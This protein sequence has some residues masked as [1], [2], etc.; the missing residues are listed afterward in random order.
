[1][2]SKPRAL[3]ITANYWDIPYRVGSHELASL[4]VRNGWLV[5]FVSDPISPL[6]LFNIKDQLIQER[7]KLYLS[8]GRKYLDDKLWAYIPFTLLPPQNF[9]IL[10][11]KFVFKNWHRLTFPNIYKKIKSQNF[12]NVDLLYFDNA[13]QAV[14]LNEIKYKKSVFRI[15]DNYAGYAKYTA[16][17]KTLE[18]QLTA[19]VDLTLYTAQNLKNYIKGI[20]STNSL[21]FPNG[22]N[23]EN[24]ANGVKAEPNELRDVPHPRIIYIGEME[25]RFD[26]NL[27]KFAAKKLPK[28]S[29]VLI[30]NEIK[31]KNEFRELKN[32]YVLGTRKSEEL[33]SYL[34]NSDVGIIPFDINKM[35]KLINY[36]NPIKIHQYFACGLP[37]VSARWKELE[38]M[39][40]KALLYD[41][42]EEFVN[43]LKKAASEDF[44]KQELIE[45]ARKSDWKYRYEQLIQHLGFSH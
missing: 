24:F 17:T 45:D 4:F 21:Y 7:F 18:E 15:A 29:F 36:V 33:S 2:S 6:H 43:L 10:K 5:G 44:N 16:Y 37:V 32:I 14:W 8:G 27:I 11:S 1:M 20:D 28:Y 26:F 9:P 40:T 42:E 12:D 39:N 23:F 3:F 34:H 31:A 13:T 19:R 35:G 38:N 22:V 25:V 41:N 30:G